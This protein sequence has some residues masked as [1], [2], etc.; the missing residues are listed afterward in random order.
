MLPLYLLIDFIADCFPLLPLE[1]SNP[2]AYCHHPSVNRTQI[3][4]HLYNDHETL[5]YSW[6]SDCSNELASTV[7]VLKKN[8]DGQLTT[9]F[10]I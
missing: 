3:N 1:G 4:L 10:C 7:V 2:P 6:N 5:E 9:A 8:T